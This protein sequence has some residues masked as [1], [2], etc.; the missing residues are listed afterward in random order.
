MKTKNWLLCGLAIS[1]A[2]VTLDAQAIPTFARKTGMP[3]SSCHYAVPALNA[4]GRQFK[5]EGF[6]LS[7]AVKPARKFNDYLKL[8]KAFPISA[9][10]VARPY[11]KT[12]GNKANIEALHELELYVAGSFGE[13]WSGFLEFAGEAGGDFSAGVD[14][15]QVT[16]SA[17]PQLNFQIAMGPTF[18][19]DPYDTLTHMRRLTVGESSV[20]G[21]AFGGADGPVGENRQYVSINGRFAN[22]LFYSVG[23]GSLIDNAEGADPQTFMG[24]VAY[25]ITPN[26]M[27]G[28]FTVDGTCSIASG[29]PDCGLADRSFSRS[30]LDF[31]ADVSNWR[32]TG[33][34]MQAKDDDINGMNKETNDVM[35]GRV[36]YAFLKD[37]RPIWVPY[38]QIDSHEKFNG[39]ETITDSTIGLIRFFDENIKG[40]IEYTNTNG[41]GTTPDDHRL[42]FQLAAY[43]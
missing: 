2:F 34:L 7:E 33:V 35:T 14:H 23:F 26:I 40:T 37:D 13:K 41:D 24:R 10:L 31:Q 17:S 1:F 29:S 38:L 25:D 18:W 11:D 6:R 5:M 3:C 8:D 20:I 30:G 12:K 43:F 19:S 21:D 32:F 15:G 27:F 16:Y 42:V 36:T 4:L 39:T 9:A 28:A 22:K